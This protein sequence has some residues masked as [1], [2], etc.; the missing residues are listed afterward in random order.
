VDEG[1]WL[2]LADASKALTVTVD[3]LRHRVRKGEL[4]S[5]RGN[6]GRVQVLVGGEPLASADQ[7]DV[8]A[9]IALLREELAAASSRAARAEGELMGLREALAR[10]DTALAQTRSDLAEARHELAEARR[11]WLERLL[12]AVRRR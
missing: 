11:G 1:R 7:P 2:T 8:G 5:R 9:E 10:A 12:E 4:T 6:D 3:A